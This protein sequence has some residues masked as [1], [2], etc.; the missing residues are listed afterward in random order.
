QLPP[1]G[2]FTRAGPIFQN[3]TDAWQCCY[4]PATRQYGIAHINTTSKREE[5]LARPDDRQCKYTVSKSD[6]ESLLHADLLCAHNNACANDTVVL[7]KQLGAMFNPLDTTETS[8]N[9]LASTTGITLVCVGAMCAVLFLA[10]FVNWR[11]RRPRRHSHEGLFSPFEFTT[12][13][14]LSKLSKTSLVHWRLHAHHLQMVDTSEGSS[15]AIYCGRPVVIQATTATHSELWHEIHLYTRVE[16]PYI[17]NFIG[18]LAWPPHLAVAFEYMEHGDLRTFLEHSALEFPWSQKRDCVVDIV[19]GLL[20][21]HGL[22]CAH[23]ALT[24][25]HVWL[26]ATLLAKLAFNHVL[27]GTSHAGDA[28][29]WTAPELLTQ[30]GPPTPAAD[31]YA[32]GMIVWEM[33]THAPPFAGLQQHAQWSDATLYGRIAQY[34][35]AEPTFSKACPL[36]MQ[37]LVLQCTAADPRERP[38]AA[39]LSVVLDPDMLDDWDSRASS[40]SADVGD[41][42]SYVS[43]ATTA[44]WGGLTTCRTAVSTEGSSC[45]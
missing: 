37:Q 28:F 36:E 41:T 23:G 34:K 10:V 22:E 27:H 1:N 19:Q 39:E 4:C 18:W 17:L 42:E 12:P 33:D 7:V 40:L 44:E 11:R 24:S 43:R 35:V 14:G 6:C 20:Y 31:M 30:S 2:D 21:L 15:L 32:L 9:G 26:N 45:V 8:K 16:S 3:T 13:K 29:R 38:T 25:R 5:C